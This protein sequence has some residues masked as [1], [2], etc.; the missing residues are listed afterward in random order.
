MKT[1]RLGYVPNPLHYVPNSFWKPTGYL[2][3]QDVS[4]LVCRGAFHRVFRDGMPM[5]SVK[6][7]EFMSPVLE[8]E[9]QPAENSWLSWNERGLIS[10]IEEEK[11]KQF[12]L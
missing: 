12:H 2:S 3:L 6:H 9:R 11:K 7:M 1:S 8:W 5:P 4:S 10:A